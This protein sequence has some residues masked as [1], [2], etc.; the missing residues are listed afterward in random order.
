VSKLLSFSHFFSLF[1]LSGVKKK[2]KKQERYNAALAGV[3]ERYRTSQHHYEV[4]RVAATA[5]H[6]RPS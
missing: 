5:P 3:V 6:C 2:T 4:Q 1:K